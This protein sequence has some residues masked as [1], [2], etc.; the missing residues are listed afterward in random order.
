MREALEAL[1]TIKLNF[2]PEGLFTLNL[3]LAFIMFGVALEIKPEHFRR[4]LQNPKSTIVGFFSQF[5]FL[6]AVTFLVALALS[7]FITPPGNI[8]PS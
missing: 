3:T 6:P 8:K 4:I 7:G 2:S 5:F 1:D